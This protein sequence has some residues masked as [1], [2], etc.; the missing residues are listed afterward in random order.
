[1]FVEFVDASVKSQA[2]RARLLRCDFDV[3][4]CDAAAPACSQ[5]F[6]HRFLGGEA[7]GIMLSGDRFAARVTIGALVGSENTLDETRRAR[8]H[9]TH[10]TNFDDVYTDRNN[11]G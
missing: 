3:L 10:A 8:E 5:G 11:H 4:P 6:E 9:L 1:M 7:R 2:G